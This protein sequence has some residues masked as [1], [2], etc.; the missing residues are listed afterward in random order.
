[1]IT[2]YHVRIGWQ[3]EGTML[4]AELAFS[5]NGTREAFL[6][7]DA[8]DSE[9]FKL[10]D[11]WEGRVIDPSDYQDRVT[12]LFHAMVADLQDQHEEHEAEG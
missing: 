8:M 5:T 11:T 10:L 12:D 4:T 2:T 6:F 7:S 9:D 3:H 1:M